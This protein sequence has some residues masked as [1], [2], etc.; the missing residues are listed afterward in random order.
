MT[1]WLFSSVVLGL[2]SPLMMTNSL[3]V[4]A[5]TQPI[6]HNMA[7]PCNDCLHLVPSDKTNQ[8]NNPIYLLR[9]YHQGELWDT[10]E[11]VVGRHFTQNRNRH[12]AGTEAPLP[13]GNYRISSHSV[14]G[15]LAEVGGRFLPVY[16]QFSTGR[17]AL[18]I[19]FDPSYNKSNGEDG[20]A[21][22]IGLS[23]RQRFAKLLNF[24]ET[25]KPQLL[26]V[27]IQ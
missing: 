9:V 12:Q 16:P 26:I 11:T 13:D 14:P 5:E 6:A 21:G 25:N 20:T 22:C 3:T 2:L 1:R 27:D 18:G 17:S 4:S 24:V 10:F 19:H 15:T 23:S 8:Q 7:Q